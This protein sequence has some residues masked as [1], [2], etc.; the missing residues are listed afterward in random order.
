MARSVNA[1]KIGVFALVCGMLIVGAFIW[2]EALT[3]FQATRTYVSYFNESVKGLQKDAVVNYLGVG[4]GHVASIGIAPDGRLVEVHISLKSDFQVDGTIAIQLREQGLT[5]LQ[6]LEIDKAPENIDQLTPKINFPTKYP[7]L[8]S[9]PSDIEQLK[10][11]L[12]DLFQKLSSLDLKALTDSW[13]KT[14]ELINNF[15]VQVVG[16]QQ[17]GDLKA[18]IVY[19]RKTAEASSALMQ[20]I[21]NAASQQGVNKGFQD[22]TATLAATRQASETLANQLKS[23]PPDVLKKISGQLGEA[24]TSG[25]SV[26]SNLNSKIG[27]STALL[28]QDLQELKALLVRLNSVVESLKEQPNRIVFPSKEKEPFQKR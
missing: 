21:S 9:Y 10:L 3:Y 27:D 26:F 14:S 12:Q 5:G 19:L 15:I 13:T 4:V 6:Y 20:R 23:L 18:T 25:T 2:L 28:Q 17:T 24:V 1:F 7:T 22:L 16:E 8:R 11:A